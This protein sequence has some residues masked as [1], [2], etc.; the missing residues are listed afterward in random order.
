MC[1]LMN[2]L[3]NRLRRHISVEFIGNEKTPANIKN[4]TQKYMN[5]FDK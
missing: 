5:D 3:I 4:K 1:Q 2:D